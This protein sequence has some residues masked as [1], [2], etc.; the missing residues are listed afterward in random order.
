MTT[1]KTTFIAPAL[2]FLLFAVPLTPGCFS[3]HYITDAVS[4]AKDGVIAGGLR[5]PSRGDGH[6]WLYRVDPSSGRRVLDL[7]DNGAQWRTVRAVS[8]TA[9]GGFVAADDSCRYTDP[10]HPCSSFVRRF[11]PEGVLVWERDV[12]GSKRNEAVAVFES[13][14]GTIIF[15]G[16]GARYD[17]TMGA[18]HNTMEFSRL[19]S[20]GRVVL[21]KAFDGRIH[22]MRPAPGGFLVAAQ[23]REEGFGRVFTDSMDATVE[24]RDAEFGR[25][26]MKRLDRE[27]GN[28]D[29]DYTSV[30]RPA[31]G[32]GVLAVVQTSGGF[33]PARKGWVVRLDAARGVMWEWLVYEKEENAVTDAVALDDG[34]A[35]VSG[36]LRPDG[37]MHG[38]AFAA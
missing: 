1:G 37:V 5:R 30:A 14:D 4:S 19:D 21:Q 32:G 34:G 15:A 11:S 9:D 20:T 10:A 38:T 28:P 3:N 22:D 24:L 16:A 33:K 29:R 13:G 2:L 12:S 6:Y 26:W 31:P 7:P 25:V 35:I 8:W 18:V 23:E 17:H 36:V 27:P